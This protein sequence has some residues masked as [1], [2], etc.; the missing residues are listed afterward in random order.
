MPG[1]VKLI[2][3]NDDEKVLMHT[4]G[5]GLD[6]PSVRLR[7]GN[8]A[9]VAQKYAKKLGIRLLDLNVIGH[10]PD[11]WYISSQLRNGD[12]PKDYDWRVA[13][14]ITDIDTSSRVKTAIKR[15]KKD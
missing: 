15:S 12:A 5:S 6:L 1:Y 8:P 4:H 14:D 3:L 7:G 11:A 10:F 13:E 2:F 9:V